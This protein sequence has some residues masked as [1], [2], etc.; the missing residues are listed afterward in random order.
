MNR[1]DQK[2]QALLNVARSEGEHAFDAF[3]E[4]FQ[5]YLRPEVIEP[6]AAKM[7]GQAQDDIEDVAQEVAK[8]LLEGGYNKQPRMATIEDLARY[9]RTMTHNCCVNIR[10]YQS[11]RRFVVTSQA[12]EQLRLFNMPEDMLACL[13]TLDLKPV[14]KETFL[15]K[16]REALGK[17]NEPFKQAI[18]NVCAINIKR[19]LPLDEVAP[20]QTPSTPADVET[21]ERD[22]LDA[23]RQTVSE[24]ERCM[25]NWQL[26]GLGWKEIAAK[27]NMPTS[28]AN[29]HYKR[30]VIKIRQNE[31]LRAAWQDYVESLNKEERT[32]IWQIN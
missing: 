18:L 25:I 16:I 13:Q 30:M 29:G 11:C 19:S 24:E 9:V 32:D 12:I 4:L 15:K 26:Q 10:S 23:I 27:L 1:P 6:E 31:Q 5:K 28:T 22:A 2:W 14:S 17:E 8:K 3:D 20:P 7:L 21:R